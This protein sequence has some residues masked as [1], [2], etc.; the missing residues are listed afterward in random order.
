VSLC[1]SQVVQ[2]LSALIS[3]RLLPWLRFNQRV[4]FI[5]FEHNDL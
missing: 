4:G 2:G 5:T 3:M 1:M